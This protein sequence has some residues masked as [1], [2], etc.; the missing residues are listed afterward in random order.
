[1]PCLSTGL[2]KLIYVTEA[3]SAPI[4]RLHKGFRFNF[5]SF[6]IA[7]GSRFLAY[8]TCTHDVPGHGI[9]DTKGG[10]K[11]HGSIKQVQ[12]DTIELIIYIYRLTPLSIEIGNVQ[13]WQPGSGPAVVFASEHAKL[14]GL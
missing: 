12:T 7:S 2:L 5:Q 14:S 4:Y 10:L 9:R 6:I 11:G 8:L 13:H 3:Q 1:M